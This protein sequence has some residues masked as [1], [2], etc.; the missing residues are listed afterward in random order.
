MNTVIGVFDNPRDA[1]PG[2]AMLRDSRYAFEDISLIS[3]AGDKE[4]AVRGGDDVP[5]REGATVGAVWHEP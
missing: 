2:I 4:V 3:K 5:A 1:Q